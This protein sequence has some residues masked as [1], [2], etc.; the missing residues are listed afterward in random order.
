MWAF[1]SLFIPFSRAERV[2]GKGQAPG[3]VTDSLP[4]RPDIDGPVQDFMTR[5]KIP[6]VSIAVMKDGQ[7]LYARG[8]GYADSASGEKVSPSSLFRIASLSKF[9]TSVTIMKLA[10]QGKLSLDAKVFGPGAV[11]GTRYG[12]RPYRKYVTAITVRQLLQHIG[13]GWGNSGDDPMFTDPSRSKDKLISWTLDSI[14]LK[15]A[16]GTAYEYSNFGYC[17]LGRVIEKI[18]G[19]TYEDY[20]RQAVLTP[21]GIR[22]M[23]IGGNKLADRKKNEVKYYGQEGEDPYIYNIERM[24]AHGGWI[25]SATDLVELMGHVDGF[26]ARRNIL[27]P[28]M[29]R[30]MVKAPA[31]SPNYACGL[32]VDRQDNW[33]H[34]GSLPGT[35]T[36]LRRSSNGICYAVLLNT[37][38]DDDTSF[39]K[40]LNR[41]MATLI[42]ADFTETE[43]TQRMEAAFPVIEALYRAHAEKNHI[44]GLA[45]GIVDHG[46]LVYAGGTGYTNT[47][48]KIPVTA[49]S[50]FRIA[51][52]TKSFTAMAILTLRD[53]GKLNLEDPVSKYIPEMKQIK[54]L[55]G[56]AREITV[57]DLLT[58]SA[59]FPEDNPWG[60]RQLQKTDEDLINFIKGGVSLSN[61][62]GTNY[63][64]SNLGFALLGHIVSKVSGTPFEKYINETIFA[65]LHMSHTYW[66]YT[67]VSPDL[68]VHG[69]SWKNGGW[70]E[71]EMLHSGA[72]GA[73]GGLLTSVEDFSKYMLLH[74]SAWPARGGEDDGPLK[75]SSIRGM[76]QP[77][78]IASLNSQA[79]NSS[80]ALCPKIS[81]YND[82]LAWSK[83]CTGKEQVGHSGG[84]PGFGT[85]WTIVPQYGI[86]VVSFA[87]LTY[88]APVALNFQVIDTLIAMEG[89]APRPV[90]VS[91]ILRERKE[92]LLRLLPDWKNARES[93]IFS[94]NFFSDYSTDTLRKDAGTAFAA[95]GK[96]LRISDM[97]PDNQ[98]RGNFILEG[99]NA[100]IQVRFTLTPENPALIQEYHI[101]SVPKK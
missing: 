4:E 22:D 35:R 26:D 51:S 2:P 60:D 87:S 50:V 58:H 62:P 17:V 100:D 73:M 47:D 68:L 37:R 69:Y 57:R 96:I 21:S 84:L 7:L 42:N 6:G 75:R 14:P 61:T 3:I 98:L 89:L 5:N 56:D 36:E 23:Q 19:Q 1:A 97:I 43:R 80:G 38:R 45:F 78:E 11:L 28:V 63:E 12:K 48:K 93:G 27:S 88:A 8:Y 31:V 46:K 55:T 24:D 34:N 77:G 66:E 94:G 25:A 70:V 15:H 44:P 92:E 32:A 53:A 13:G 76:H 29:I 59:G 81:S 18:T 71:E 99:E 95:A 65:P 83:D 64:Y 67:D 52:M 41:I 10:E 33:Y 86:G 39:T 30:T 74:L 90:P 9:V 20:V 82:G 79:K 101:R 54:P 16:P 91:A 49:A 72:Y 40:G 85:H